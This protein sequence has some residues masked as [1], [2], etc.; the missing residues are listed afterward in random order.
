M[1][2]KIKIIF[3]LKNKNPAK[4]AERKGSKNGRYL[5]NAD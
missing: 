4:N 2:L 5:H 3:S 1:K